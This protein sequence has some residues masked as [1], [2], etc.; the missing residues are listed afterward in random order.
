MTSNPKVNTTAFIVIG[1]LLITA[2][3]MAGYLLSYT[4]P[5]RI[6]EREITTTPI[7][8]ITPLPTA[9]PLVTPA[10]AI[11]VM[12]PGKQVQSVTC[13]DYNQDTSCTVR[14]K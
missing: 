8:T 4:Q 2:F 9:Y 3:V 5:E 10:T 11:A 14:L 13:Y 12:L 1:F 7:A 6:I